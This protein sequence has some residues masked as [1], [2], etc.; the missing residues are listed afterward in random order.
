[1]KGCDSR[2]N[3]DCQ[4]FGFPNSGKLQTI[5]LEQ[6]NCKEFD[7]TEKS[8]IC[9]KHFEL[10]SF[11]NDEDNVTK[12]G[13]K[14]KGKSLLSWSYPTLLLD[15][16]KRKLIDVGEAGTESLD[17]IHNEEIEGERM[18]EESSTYGFVSEPLVSIKTEIQ[19]G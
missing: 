2:E 15:S 16:R 17:T 4:L 14:R 19:G 8:K 1:M 11:M 12:K 9:E 6:L 10:Q 7:L 18:K 5:W 13:R 3:E